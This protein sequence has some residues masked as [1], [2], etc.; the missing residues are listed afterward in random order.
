MTSF[1]PKWKIS[2]IFFM[3]AVNHVEKILWGWWNWNP[4]ELVH[5]RTERGRGADG[6]FAWLLDGY[7]GWWN[8]FYH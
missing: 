4:I 2:S 7:L 6:Q 3:N 8:E 1:V 5:Y